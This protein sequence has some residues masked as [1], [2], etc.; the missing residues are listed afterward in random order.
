VTSHRPPAVFVSR[1]RA[2]GHSAL[3]SRA[4]LLLR[5]TPIQDH[6]GKV[7]TSIRWTDIPR[8]VGDRPYSRQ[9][10]RPT[11]NGAHVL[12]VT[13]PR[14]NDRSYIYFVALGRF[15]A[16]CDTLGDKPETCTCTTTME[17]TPAPRS[18]SSR[19]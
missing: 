3:L 5:P 4:H 9:Q 17:H 8:R 10:T 13:A 15:C 14:A 18:P 2:T 7:E 6:P 1:D 12:G 19:A 11:A 16:G